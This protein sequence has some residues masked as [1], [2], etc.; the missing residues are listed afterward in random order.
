M[1]MSRDSFFDYMNCAIFISKGK[2]LLK[3][4]AARWRALISFRSIERNTIDYIL[5]V[6]DSNL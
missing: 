3:Y 4:R 1:N 5:K 6:Y 2:R